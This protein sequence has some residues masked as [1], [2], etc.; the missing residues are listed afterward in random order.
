VSAKLSPFFV[1][2]DATSAIPSEVPP[3]SAI[4]AWK[5]N[6]VLVLGSKNRYPSVFPRQISR[7]CVG[8]ILIILSVA[9]NTDSNFGLS[10]SRTDMMSFWKKSFISFNDIYWL[11]YKV[12]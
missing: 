7:R 1:E 10:K 12:F 5:L 11:L 4:A 3:I 8:S 2:E 6:L 9:E